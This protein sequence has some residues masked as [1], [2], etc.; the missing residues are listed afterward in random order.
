MFTA[1]HDKMDCG[2][3]CLKMI[4]SFYKKN[5]SLRYLREKSFL[6]REGVSLLGISEAAQS[7]GFETITTKISLEQL[8]NLPR[9]SILHWKQNHFVVLEKIKGSK[10]NKKN[11]ISIFKK[12]LK[13][14]IAD[15]SYGFLYFKESDFLKNWINN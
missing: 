12:N 4:C 7:I 1:Q 5:Y 6:T 14:K 13:F 15:P 11:I 2:P 10:N 3:A 9:P 8:L